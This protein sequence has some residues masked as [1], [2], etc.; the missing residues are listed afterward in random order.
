MFTCFGRVELSNCIGNPGIA[1]V[2]MP[3][4]SS[5]ALRALVFDISMHNCPVTCLSLSV[6]VFCCV[7]FSLLFV[8]IP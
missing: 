2:Y 4:M 8:L 7:Y 3:H 6:S 1:D 5:E